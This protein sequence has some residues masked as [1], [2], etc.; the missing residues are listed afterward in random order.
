MGALTQLYAG[1]APEAGKMNGEVRVFF[2]QILLQLSCQRV[3]RCLE[4]CCPYSI[5]YHLSLQSTNV[6]LYSISSRGPVVALYG[7]T[8]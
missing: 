4:A 2:D 5:F 6:Y 1:T 8:H 3:L 7:R